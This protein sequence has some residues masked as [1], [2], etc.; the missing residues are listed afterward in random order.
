[1]LRIAA[2]AALS[3]SLILSSTGPVSAVDEGVDVTAP[4]VTDPGLVVGQLVG[5]SL[6]LK[7]AY[8]D[9]VG[10]VIVEVLVDGKRFGSASAKQAEAG[11]TISLAAIPHDAELDITVRAYDATR[12]YG[13]VTTRVRMDNEFPSATFPPE[14]GTLLHGRA[15]LRA[16][17]V[18]GDVARIVLHEGYGGEISRA[19][20]APW[21]LALDTTGNTFDRRPV[22]FTVHDRAGNSTTYHRSYRMDNVGPTVHEVGASGINGTA[23]AGL[24]TIE[25]W[26]TDPSGVDRV[27]WWAGGTLRHTGPAYRYDFGRTSGSVPFTIKAWDKLGQ[28][29]TTAVSVDVDA[30]DPTVTWVTPANG[31]LVRGPWIPTTIRFSDN[32][33]GK[34]AAWFYGGEPNQPGPVATAR[35]ALPQDGKRELI[36][37]VTDSAFN[38]VEVRRTVIVDNTRPA[39]TVTKAPRNTAKVKGIVKVTASAS[40]RNGVAR[41]ELLINGKVVAR[42]VKAGYAFSIDT[43]KYGKKIKFQLRAYDKAGNVRVTTARTWRR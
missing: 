21:V 26:V 12:K 36:W 10:V 4:V 13:E 19:T 5:R 20:E 15:E 8:R 22:V 11:L 3:S 38:A 31:A 40:D 25:A 41:V 33:A 14:S 35:A 24:R 32:G 7:P 27:E 18:S 6:P 28:Q 39:L 16:S 34:P 17:E 9:D 37:R 2:V 43:R 29:S 30:V 42:D 1:M 23:G